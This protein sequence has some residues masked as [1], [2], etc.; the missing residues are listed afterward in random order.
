MQRIDLKQFDAETAVSFDPED[1]A[2]AA[3]IVLHSTVAFNVMFSLTRTGDGSKVIELARTPGEPH[4][5]TAC[6]AQH[7]GDGALRR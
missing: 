1:G 7:A 6:D 2:E 3:G 5:R 4:R